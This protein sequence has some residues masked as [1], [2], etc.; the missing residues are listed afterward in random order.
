MKILIRRFEDDRTGYINY[1][2]IIC[3]S[4]EISFS[5]TLRI[6][7]KI[8]CEI[9]HGANFYIIVIILYGVRAV[10]TTGRDRKKTY[11][12]Y[13]ASYRIRS[14]SKYNVMYH[15]NVLKYQIIT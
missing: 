7:T 9:R 12:Y 13:F 8:L 1:I 6:P 10:R 15:I 5:I 11:Y 14:I 4:H 3:S 2:Y